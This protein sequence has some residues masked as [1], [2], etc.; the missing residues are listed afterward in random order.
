MPFKILYDGKDNNIITTR[1]RLSVTL[2]NIASSAHSQTQPHLGTE[3]HSLVVLCSASTQTS[4]SSY[5]IHIG[6]LKRCNCRSHVIM[7]V[8]VYK[9]SILWTPQNTHFQFILSSHFC[10]EWLSRSIF[11]NRFLIINMTYHMNSLTMRYVQKDSTLTQASN[12][13]RTR[14][15]LG[16]KPVTTL[17]ESEV[18]FCLNPPLGSS[19]TFWFKAYCCRSSGSGCLCELRDCSCNH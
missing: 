13:S 17:K 8:C 10:T 16:F 14:L 15:R 19:R 18:G 4:V 11:N 6:W 5:S 3:E 7:G 9:I 1:I 12:F 2:L